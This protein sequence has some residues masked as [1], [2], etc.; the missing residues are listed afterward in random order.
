MLRAAV[1]SLLAQQYPHWELCMADD[2]STDPGVRPLLQELAAAD[3]RIRVVFRPENGHISAATNSA[4]EMARY[5]YCALLDQDDTLSVEAFAKA[6]EAIGRH[7]DA[8]LLYSDEVIMVEGRKDIAPY[9]KPDWDRELLYGQNYVSHLGIYRT[10]RLREIGG[11]RPG[12]DGSQDYDMLLRFSRGLAEDKILHLPLVLYRWRS[13][14]ASAASGGDAKPYAGI[15]GVKALQ[16]YFALEGVKVSIKNYGTVYHVYHAPPSPLPLVSFIISCGNAPSA[17]YRLVRALSG[18]PGYA[19]VQ[20]ILTHDENLSAQEAA[21]VRQLRQG[22]PRAGFMAFS[23]NADEA[24]KANAAAGAAAGGILFFL[25]AGL[26]PVAS[27]PEWLAR[28][29]G[30][31]CR[32]GMGAVGGRILDNRGKLFAA[33]YQTDAGGVLFSLFRGLPGNSSYHFCQAVL[34]RSVA[35]AHPWHFA[36]PAKVFASLGGL[37]KA[38]GAP[39]IEYCLRLRE[40][41]FGVSVSPL[42]DF[43]FAAQPPAP[44]WEDAGVVSDPELLATLGSRLKPYHPDLVARDNLWAYRDPESGDE[45]LLIPGETA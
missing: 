14:P 26:L 43:T 42:A 2:A 44:P 19:K 41:G 6:A 29:V 27:S 23:A 38:G 1:A 9:C 11:F 7:P 15:S 35:A 4:L 3:P 13:H 20:L 8:E 37:R 12:F 25:H 36:T 34:A 40:S 5:S 24:E 22:W 17:A 10:R 39:A 33:G 32:P 31:V 21:A 16:E 45:R 18:I 28:M 30:H